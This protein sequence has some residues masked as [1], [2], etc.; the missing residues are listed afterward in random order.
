MSEWLAEYGLGALFASAFISS[1]LLPGGSELLFFTMLTEEPFPP[2]LLLIVV[3]AGNSLGGAVTFSMGA[4]LAHF[5][6][7]AE[8]SKHHLRASRWIEKY[9]HLSLLLSWLPLV[10]DPLCFVA[11]IMKV[12]WQLAVLMIV[13]GK[14]ARYGALM[15]L[16]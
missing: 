7:V 16:S 15:L 8:F 6:K 12:K 10:G 2:L 13:I 4:W 1:T 11:G 14:A 3:T 5:N 9:G